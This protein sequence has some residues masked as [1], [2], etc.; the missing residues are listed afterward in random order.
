M[1]LQNV[2]V[3]AADEGYI[4]HAKSV[5][6]NCMRQGEWKGDFCLILPPDVDT[7]YFR[8]RGIYVL[9][10]PAP[11]YYR[12]FAVFDQFF[13]QTYQTEWDTPEHKWDRVLY[14]DADVLVQNPLEPLMHEVGWGTI[15]ADR[16]LWNLQHAF[17]NWSTPE[18]RES[19]AA[20]EV[21]D[22]LW[23]NYGPEWAQYNT[24]VM[25]YH[26]RTMPVDAREQLLAMQE[27]IAPIN[28]HVVKG[29]DQPIFNLTFYRMFERVRSELFC[30]YRS[31]WE[32]TIVVH[33][34]SGYAPWINKTPKMAAY[35]NHKLGRPCH[36]VYL[37][38]LAAF[39]ETFP[40]KT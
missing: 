28:T 29:T 12:K 26:P 10:D 25:L 7:E 23:A 31:A 21:L 30:Y 1:L 32:K 13:N 40:V 20:M 5:L 11:A 3:L 35:F 14:L 38:N 4:P 17:T 39:E 6:V 22:W 34:C 33:Y 19:P 8:S 27:R 2:V 9:T 15:L 36:D 18:S 37:E 24:G 16:E